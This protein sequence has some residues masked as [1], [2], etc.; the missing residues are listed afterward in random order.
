MLLSVD[1]DA[2][3]GCVEHVFDA[4]IWGTRDRA[5]DRLDA[6]VARTRNRDPHAQD[7]TPLAGDF[8]LHGDW[9]ALQQYAGLP[10]ALSWTHADAYA[11]VAG[12]AGQDVVNVDSHHDLVSY[13]GDPAR[14]RPGNWAGLALARG[15]IRTYTV[16]Y[17][18]WHAHVRVAEGYD[19]ERTRDE[20][21]AHLPTDL[22]DRVRLERTDALPPA[23]DVT[24]VLLVQSPAWTNPAHDDAFRTVAAALRAHAVQP[25]Y[26]RPWP[27]P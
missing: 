25:S 4:P 18:A 11:W 14:V 19:L 21:R 13:S 2:Y 9:V 22:L 8:P 23:R 3:S 5:E 10:A 7:W 6:W 27:A 12:H 15:L 17:P 20:L 24:G 26:V 16:R 1:W